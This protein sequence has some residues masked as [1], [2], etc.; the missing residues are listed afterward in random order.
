[1][2]GCILSSRNKKIAMKRKSCALIV[3]DNAKL[4]A[5]TVSNALIIRAP[6][7]RT[8]LQVIIKKLLKIFEL[9]TVRRKLWRQN[10]VKTVI[11]SFK[12]VTLFA[13]L[14][15]RL[16]I[17]IG[18]VVI[19]AITTVITIPNHTYSKLLLI[20]ILTGLADWS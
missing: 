12:I 15:N 2:R 6:N 16:N 5:T 20:S 13:R 10:T 8:K 9:M 18:F 1:M 19:A 17:T 3:R 14:A 7:A 11:T 4:Q